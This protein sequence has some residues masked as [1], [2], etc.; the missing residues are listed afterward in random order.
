MTSKVTGSR[1]HRT[2]STPVCTAGLADARGRRD[3]E[4]EVAVDERLVVG[5]DD[6]AVAHPLRRS[7]GRRRGCPGRSACAVVDGRG[8]EPL[9]LEVRLALAGQRRRGVGVAQLARVERDRLQ[10]AGA[11]DAVQLELQRPAAE[12]RALAVE[13]AVALGEARAQELRRA[14]VERAGVDVH[15]E[16]VDLQPVADAERP[17]QRDVVAGDALAGEL[18]EHPGLQRRE[19]AGH[20]REVLRVERRHEL[21]RGLLGVGD[22][23]GE[24]ALGRE[25]GR[26]GEDEDRLRPDVVAV[27]GGVGR[28]GAA[29]GDEHELARVVALLDRRLADQVGHLAR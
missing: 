3:R 26:V 2:T 6:D 8:A 24:H 28:P 9:G 15:V 1:R 17:R 25:R 5:R 22:V 16:R 18:V 7:P 10:R 20:R 23:A 19:V 13:M 21:V 12:Q 29:V 14:L 4:R 11:D 27:E